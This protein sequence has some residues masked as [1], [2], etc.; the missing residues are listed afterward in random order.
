MSEQPTGYDCMCTP[1]GGVLI[2]ASGCPYGEQPR[3]FV[4]DPVT[5]P[6]LPPNIWQAGIEMTPRL[7]WVDFRPRMSDDEV[8]RIADRVVEKLRKDT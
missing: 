5:A 7:G 4:S 6:A 8:E 2:H 3:H 1:A